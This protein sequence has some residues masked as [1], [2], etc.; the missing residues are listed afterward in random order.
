MLHCSELYSP[1]LHSPFPHL[2]FHSSCSVPVLAISIPHCGVP[3]HSLQN[4][5]LQYLNRFRHRLSL[6]ISLPSF[7]FPMLA[8]T[9]NSVTSA[10]TNSTALSPPTNPSTQAIPSTQHGTPTTSTPPPPRSASTN[11]KCTLRNS[12]PRN[13][14]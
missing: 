3:F 9:T 14:R 13:Q 5:Q 11:A 4:D 10:K 1:Y 8:L 2:I 6:G 7:P 12:G